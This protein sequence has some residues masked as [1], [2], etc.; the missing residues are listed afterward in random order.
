MPIQ[1]LKTKQRF[2]RVSPPFQG[3][4]GRWYLNFTVYSESGRFDFRVTPLQGARAAA[5]LLAAWRKWETD[6]KAP[7]GPGEQ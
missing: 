4:D 3:N 6:M 7:G 5:D 2:M 1:M